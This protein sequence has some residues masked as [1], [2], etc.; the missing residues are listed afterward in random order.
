MKSILLTYLSYRHN[1][2][3]IISMIGLWFVF[4]KFDVFESLYEISRTYEDIE[5]DEL[6]LLAIILPVLYIVSSKFNKKRVDLENS[7]NH[8]LNNMDAPVSLENDV[9]YKSDYDANWIL[10]SSEAERLVKNF[11]DQRGD[12]GF[13][14]EEVSALLNWAN[15]VRHYEHI[16]NMVQ[17]NIIKVDVLEEKIKIRYN[18]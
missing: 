2:L 8:L 4:T 17:K 16:L 5:S 11:S 15:N 18:I 1:L 13:S 6:I 7:Y 3:V 12:A 14:D 10:G 9:K